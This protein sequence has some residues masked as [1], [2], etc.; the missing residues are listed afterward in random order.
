[1]RVE[2]SPPPADFQEQ[3]ATLLAAALTRDDERARN[4]M[5]EMPI[6]SEVFVRAASA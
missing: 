4:S 5:M 6:S 3:L 1:L 2:A